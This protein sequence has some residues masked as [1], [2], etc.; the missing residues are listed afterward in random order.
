MQF[1]ASNIKDTDKGKGTGVHQ[2]STFHVPFEGQ[3][4]KVRTATNDGAELL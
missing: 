3:D 4:V 2:D 1:L